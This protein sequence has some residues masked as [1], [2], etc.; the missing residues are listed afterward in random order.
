MTERL[1]L[2]DALEPDRVRAA[3]PLPGMLV[4]VLING[5]PIRATRRAVGAAIERSE[6]TA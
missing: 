1:R 3:P 2:A 4:R 5:I 6:G